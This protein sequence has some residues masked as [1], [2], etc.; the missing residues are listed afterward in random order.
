MEWDSVAES[1]Q[2]AEGHMLQ[3]LCEPAVHW[4]ER[5]GKAESRGFGCSQVYEWPRCHDGVECCGAVDIRH[6][7]YGGCG[8]GSWQRIEQGREAPCRYHWMLQCGRRCNREG[9]LSVG[10]H[11]GKALQPSKDKEPQRV[12][13]PSP[14]SYS[15][16]WVCP[17]EMEIREGTP[18]ESCISAEGEEAIYD[19]VRSRLLWTS[20]TVTT[21][22]AARNRMR[23]WVQ[24]YS[25]PLL[26]VHANVVSNHWCDTLRL[27]CNTW[28]VNRG[29]LQIKTRTF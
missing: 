7:C 1:V 9:F 29:S 14:Q 26:M 2:S 5:E 15:P 19:R 20:S 22:S 6:L 18:Q 25:L 27:D 23:I 24:T 17:Y 11:S 21:P 3:Y 16:S 8:F 10:S 12:Y 13:V 4:G 28:V